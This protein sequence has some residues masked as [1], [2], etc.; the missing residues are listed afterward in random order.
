[1]IKSIEIKVEIEGQGIVNFDSVNQK[2]LWGRQED[3]EKIIDN[4]VTFGKGRYYS[5]TDSN[6][7]VKTD[8]YGKVIL[9]KVPVISADCIRHSM[10]E[11]NMPVHLP[12]I[13]HDKTL[14]L[15]AVATPAFL[16]RGYMF[17]MAGETS[18]RRT[19]AFKC[20]Y[21]KAVEHSVS[22]L[23]TFANSQAKTASEETAGTS[24]FKREVRG[25]MKYE[26]SGA[27]DLSELGFISL[28]DIHDRMNF[29]PD[30]AAIFADH[31]SKKM[32][33]EVSS[34]AYYNKEHNVYEIPELGIKLTEE[35]VKFLSLDILKRLARFNLA[36]TVT[37][38]AKTKSVKIKLVTDVFDDS[39]WV[40]I[41]SDNKFNSKVLDDVQLYSAYSVTDLGN[42]KKLCDEYRNNFGYVKAKTADKVDKKKKKQDDVVAEEE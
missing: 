18:W 25:E 7:K 19:S 38:W 31:L 20:S 41:F 29:N 8:Q 36:K 5:V 3:V 10:Y 15:K 32:G 24:F 6:G 35:Q 12:N 30:F 27:I 1:M 34:P 11:D 39:E 22:S 40:T 2:W 37:G 14:L 23:E 21:A 42:E 28:S 13:M 16:E 17:A 26:L 4:N 33:S 9:T